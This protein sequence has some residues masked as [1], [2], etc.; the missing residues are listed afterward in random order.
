MTKLAIRARLEADV[1]TILNAG[2]GI[3]ME[4]AGD[5]VGITAEKLA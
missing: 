4:E 1:E 2:R 3:A 5:K